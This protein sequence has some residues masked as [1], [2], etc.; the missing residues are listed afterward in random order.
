[1]CGENRVY[2]STSDLCCGGYSPGYKLNGRTEGLKC[3]QHG[4]KAYNPNTQICCPTDRIYNISEN[5]G[6]WD[7]ICNKV[8]YVVT[9]L[10]YFQFV[11]S[12]ITKTFKIVIILQTKFFC[13]V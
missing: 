10:V 6:K 3:C 5:N 8:F 2:N 7:Y 9:V 4:T 1:M 13:K 11:I 12:L